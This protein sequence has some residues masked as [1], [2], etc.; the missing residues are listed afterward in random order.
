MTD[1]GFKY[2]SDCI[3]LE[4]NETTN[5]RIKKDSSFYSN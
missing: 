1:K 2:F 3:Q 4:N 5:G